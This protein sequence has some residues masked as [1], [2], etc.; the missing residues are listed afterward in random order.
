V[1]ITVRSG[2]TS[3]NG[4]AL[5]STPSSPSLR[6]VVASY[7]GYAEWSSQPVRRLEIA[8][9]RVVLIIGL[10]GPLTVGSRQVRSFVAGL[11]PGATMTEYDDRQRGIE[12]RLTP[13]GAY[14]LLGLPLSELTGRVVDLDAVWGR[15]VSRLEERLAE[16]AG[17]SERFAV[18]D[19]EL[20]RR[21]ADGLRPDP[22]LEGAWRRLE[23]T[24]GDVRIADLTDDTGWSR[25]RLAER[26]RAQTGLTAKAL[27]RLLRFEHAVRLLTGPGHRSL[28]SVALTCGYYDQAHL[29]RDFRELAGCTPTEYLRARRS[30]A[31]AMAFGTAEPR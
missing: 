21:A 8:V 7:D 24:S 12:L 4:W 18:L 17:W 22:E 23:R 5:A 14:R 31:L 25:R 19:R 29:N 10:A 15:E 2:G 20:S 28:A 1:S 26:F 6:P 16:A 13:L 9:P 27:A 11:T 3:S 30:D